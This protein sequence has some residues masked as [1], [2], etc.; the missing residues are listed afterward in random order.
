MRFLVKMEISLYY[1]YAGIDA[2]SSMLAS[3]IFLEPTKIPAS[4]H[5]LISLETYIGVGL[6]MLSLNMLIRRIIMRIP[7]N[8]ANE[9]AKEKELEKV[10]AKKDNKKKK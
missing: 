3:F 7:V 10:N 5:F 4:A 8:F 1:C 6:I 9:E 2:W